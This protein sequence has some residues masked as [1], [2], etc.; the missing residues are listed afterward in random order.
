LKKINTVT[1]NELGRTEEINECLEKRRIDIL[2][3]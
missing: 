2:D 3:E 1:V